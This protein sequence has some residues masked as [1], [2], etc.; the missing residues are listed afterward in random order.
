MRTIVRAVA[1]LA[2]AGGLT[3]GSL[4]PAAAAPKVLDAYCSPSG[5]Y[6][7]M[8]VRKADGTISFRIRAF[9]NYF[10]KATVCVRK[11]TRVCRD[12]RPRRHD[13]LFDWSIRWQGNFPKE[14][15]GRYT[16]RWLDGD[17]RIGPALH[18]R[19]R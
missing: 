18:F 12:R 4:V 17:L 10:G 8:I 19:R 11:E 6:C 13:G 1:A 14:G 16:V 9:A 2:L 15:P 5:D 3:L 7:T